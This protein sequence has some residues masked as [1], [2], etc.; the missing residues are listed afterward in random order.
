MKRGLENELVVSP[1]SSIMTLTM[2]PTESIKNL[3]LLEKYGALGKYGF[4]EA[5]DFTSNRINKILD[6]NIISKSNKD[7]IC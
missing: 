5:I 3:R 1:Y 6:D 2:A 7:G 4:I